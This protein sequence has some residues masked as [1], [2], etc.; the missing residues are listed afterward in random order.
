MLAL[1]HKSDEFNEAD[2]SP[3]LYDLQIV[4]ALLKKTIDEKRGN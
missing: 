3:A 1:T 2:F 4:I